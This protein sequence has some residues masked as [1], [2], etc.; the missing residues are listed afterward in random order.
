MQTVNIDISDSGRTI[1]DDR[2]Y[3]PEGNGTNGMLHNSTTNEK[4]LLKLCDDQ[5]HLEAI[6][7]FEYDVVD[8]VENRRIFR[9]IVYPRI[10][11]QNAEF[12]EDPKFYAFTEL[13]NLT[14]V[15]ILRLSA[16]LTTKGFSIYSRIMAA[17]NLAEALSILC[18]YAGKN[19]LSI[20]PEDIYLNT[21]NG[22]VYIWI[23]R[24]LSKVTD[25][26]EVEDFGFD[27]EWYS[28]EDKTITEEDIRY[29]IAYVVFRV[30]CN[31]EPFDGSE[32]LLQF[33]L[34]TN[35]AIHLIHA[36]KY[37][38]VLS[39]GKNCVSEY[40][41]Q[42]LLKKWRALP[43][44][45]RSEIE[46]NFTV[47]LDSP[48]ER[49]AVSTWVKILRKLRDCL[50]FVNGQVRFC[51]PDAPN[52][53]LFMVIGEYKIPVWPQKAIY[54]YHAGLPINE[55]KNGVVAGVTLKEGHH[56]LSNLSGSV[57]GASLGKT[58]FWIQPEREI[59]IAEGMTIELENGNIIT[60]VNGMVNAPA[61]T[62]CTTIKD[63]DR[64]KG[65]I[66]VHSVTDHDSKNL[67]DAAQKVMPDTMDSERNEC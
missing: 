3:Y 64:P 27:S 8:A 61:K 20:H 30:L 31:D 49:T 37:G 2:V 51:D 62:V 43:A 47:G 60:I 39:D 42:G 67:D 29:F 50:V 14:D 26:C 55:T 18:Q 9:N 44:F 36:N 38:F 11:K 21:D 13:P 7:A 65:A 57:W 17:T 34:L 4:V 52:K 6:D 40:I 56:Y 54:W 12:D 35:E 24:W 58:T 45:L 28:R 33:P 15:K 46:K 25:L 23:E 63:K 66:C 16:A 10:L 59:E 41:G 48:M 22:E 1:I 19:I 5:E 53:V 32:T